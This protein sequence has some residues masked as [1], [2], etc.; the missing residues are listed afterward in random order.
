MK[1]FIASSFQRCAEGLKMLPQLDNLICHA[2][3]LA[4]VC[5]SQLR[6]V[7]SGRGLIRSLAATPVFLGFSGE[8][9]GE[10]LAESDHFVCN[11]SHFL[12]TPSWRWSGRI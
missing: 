2:E 5:G 1:Q 10:R 4:P 6:V 12:H 7:Q 11:V 3:S 9:V 8:I